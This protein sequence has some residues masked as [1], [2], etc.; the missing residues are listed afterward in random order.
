MTSDRITSFRLTAVVGVL[1]A[2][3]GM[4]SQ[5]NNF[6]HS[7]KVRF[8]LIGEA[9]AAETDAPGISN[10]TFI[11]S[12]VIRLLRHMGKYLGAAREFSF[13]AE[14]THDEVLSN[15]QKIQYGSVEIV[16]VR[17]PNMLHVSVSGEERQT[18]VFYDGT[19]FTIL[20]SAK[21]VYT[22]T[23]VAP[24]IDTAIDEVFDKYGFSVPIADLVYEDPY[25]TLI[26]NVE[27]G[28]LVGRPLINGKTTFHLAFT[29]K[30]IDWQI[31]I[32]DGSRPVPRKLLITYKN[33]IGSPQ[34][35]AILS[36]WNFQP[37]LSNSFAEFNSSVGSQE[38]E[39]LRPSNLPP[40]K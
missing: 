1:L 14:I 19:H 35:T 3:G 29:Q 39:F 5:W 30:T 15:A 40:R 16:E 21:M 7:S 24:T 36:N 23:K 4:C 28:Y 13:R 32:E 20:D 27:T 11:D 9:N 38:I 10:E 34:Y 33:E 18:Q 37:R 22:K 2:V 31:W 26:E 8:A 6:G 17:R 12:E 25:R